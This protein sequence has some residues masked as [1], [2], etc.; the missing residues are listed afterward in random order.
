MTV[1]SSEYRER[2]YSVPSSTWNDFTLLSPEQAITEHRNVKTSARPRS[3]LLN[4][5]RNASG[6]EG[7]AACRHNH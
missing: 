5:R 4:P 1:A 3:S 2:N 7:T 6:V